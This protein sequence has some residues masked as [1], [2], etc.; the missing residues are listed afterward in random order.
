MILMFVCVHLCSMS[1]ADKRT[2]SLF[3]TLVSHAEGLQ[4]L[5]GSLL[6]IKL[7]GTLPHVASEA[8]CSSR[9]QHDAAVVEIPAA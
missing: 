3:K 7:C 8:A 5:S 9:Q 6:H 1:S 2:F 4:S